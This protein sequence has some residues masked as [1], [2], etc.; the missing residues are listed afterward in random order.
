L[1]GVKRLLNYPMDDLRNYLEFENE[2]LFKIVASSEFK[3]KLAE[4]R[5]DRL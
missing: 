2:E 1:T 3:K 5:E 4:Y